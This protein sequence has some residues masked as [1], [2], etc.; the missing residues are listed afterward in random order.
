MTD[1]ILWFSL[2][3]GDKYYV[4]KKFDFIKITDNTTI[5]EI[6]NNARLYN[7]RAHKRL[8]TLVHKKIEKVFGRNMYTDKMECS[9]LSKH[10]KKYN[11]INGKIF[12]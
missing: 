4:D 8:F 12:V 9:S 5:Q 2:S 7:G 10:F 11:V 3:N 6:E 1:C